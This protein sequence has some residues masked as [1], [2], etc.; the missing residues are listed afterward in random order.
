MHRNCELFNNE[1]DVTDHTKEFFFFLNYMEDQVNQGFTVWRTEQ[2][3]WC[4]R[5]L[6]AGSVDLQL[7]CP[8]SMQ[9]VP[10]KTCIRLV[11]YKRSKKILLKSEFGKKGKGECSILEDVNGGGHYLLQLNIYRYLLE[12]YYDVIV[13]G[14]MWIV[15]FH[16]DNDN[17]LEYEVSDYQ[18]LVKRLFEE[19]EAE[20]SLF[21]YP[22]SYK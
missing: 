9:T 7:R 18:W 3:I 1:L 13:N 2:R 12:K 8:D 6:L 10:G 20:V 21:R 16:P 14:G 19:R 17:Y 22:V 15:V 11:D 5:I 4:E